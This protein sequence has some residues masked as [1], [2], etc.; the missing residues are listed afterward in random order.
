MVK[1]NTRTGMS[2]IW[3]N[4]EKSLL[5]SLTSPM[6]IQMFLNKLPYNSRPTALS[7]RRVLKERTA[8]CF[9]GALFAAAA[10]RLL[11]HP[12]LIVDM[13]A[14]NDD[15]HVIA[16]FKK[17]GRWGAV[18]KSNTTLLRYREPVYRSLRELVMSYFDMYFNTRGD[19]SLR[20]YSRPVNLSRFDHRHWMT[21][22]EDL[23][24]IGDFLYSIPH[25]KILTQQEIHN[26]K[27]A[28]AD[29]MKACFTGSNKAGLFKPRSPCR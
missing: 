25:K 28:D 29:I 13:E 11:G 15:D 14:K 8:H 24:F 22:D 17:G 5:R 2:G 6:E 12:P 7:P 16:V 4:K 1:S 20:T 10:L 26:L 19:K 3:T 9:E 23:E 18:A 21:T 27:R